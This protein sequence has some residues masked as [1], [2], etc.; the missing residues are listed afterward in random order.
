MTQS[1]IPKD[2]F[3][4]VQWEICKHKIDIKDSWTKL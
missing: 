2:N 4:I 1:V 3:I